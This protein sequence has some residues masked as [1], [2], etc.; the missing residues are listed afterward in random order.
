[1]EVTENYSISGHVVGSLWDNQRGVAQA[2]TFEGI[3][4]QDII[5]QAKKAFEG[6]K[7]AKTSDLSSVTGASLLLYT[8]KTLTYDG[9]KYTHKNCEPLRLGDF[10]AEDEENLINFGY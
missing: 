6:G 5:D 2:K 7:L 10:T 9:E 4:K 1:M 3:S 8:H